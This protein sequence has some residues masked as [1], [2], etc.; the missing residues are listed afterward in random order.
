M[1]ALLDN[2]FVCLLRVVQAAVMILLGYSAIINGYD[3]KT[4][5]L[6]IVLLVVMLPWGWKEK[7]SVN[8]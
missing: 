3:S 1:R 4:I 2:V 6:S 5:I 7:R 8:E